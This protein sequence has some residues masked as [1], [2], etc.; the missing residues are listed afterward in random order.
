[1]LWDGGELLLAKRWMTTPG[2]GGARG[3]AATPQ[4]ARTTGRGGQFGES[5]GPPLVKGCG[6]RGRQE[7]RAPSD[8]SFPRVGAAECA[9]LVGGEGTRRI[10]LAL[11]CSGNTGV[12]EDGVPRPGNR[13]LRRS[14]LGTPYL[15][16]NTLHPGDSRA[17]FMIGRLAVLELVLAVGCL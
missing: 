8:R 2:S 12:A 13:L 15:P 7:G 10:Q 6:S 5:A 9:A 11:S 3:L 17:A 1:M 16:V 4:Q 14:S